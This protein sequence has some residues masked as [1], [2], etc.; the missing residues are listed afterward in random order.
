MLLR[1][2][3]LAKGWI[4][5]VIFGLLILTFALWGVHSYLG[6][7]GERYVAEVN[8]EII[9][10]REF[11]NIVQT[12]RENLRQMFGGQLPADLVSDEMIRE[13]ALES[14]IARKLIE[15]TLSTYGFAVSDAEVLAHIRSQPFF[16][17]DGRFSAQRYENILKQQRIA[18]GG[19]EASVREQLRMDQLRQGVA[20]TAFVTPAE[21]DD[22]V[23]LKRQER[24]LTY[25]LISLEALRAGFAPDEAEI[26]AYYEA[27]PQSF[28]SPERVRIEYVILDEQRLR[29]EVAATEEDLRAYYQSNLD[30]YITP[31]TRR[32]SHILVPVEE[33]D[34]EAARA[35][36]EALVERIRAGESFADVA[37]EASADSLSA[38]AGG[39]LGFLARGDMEPA[40]EDVLFVLEQGQVSAPVRTELG[41]QILT[42]TE[43]KP[44]QQRP[45]AEVRDAIEQE[46]RLREA[47][48]R[49]FVLSERLRTAS[50]EQQDSLTPAAAA[51]GAELQTSDWFTLDEGTGF[52]ADAMIRRAAFSQRVLDAGQ[53]SDLLELADGRLAVL[54]VAAHEPSAPR[55]FEAVRDEA[56]A[57]LVEAGARDRVRELGRAALARLREGATLEAA[58]RGIPAT[59][60]RPGFVARDAADG[61]PP[62]LLR[63][64]FTLNRPD[65]GGQSVDGLQLASGDYALLV[66]SAVRD[67]SGDE[68]H[69]AR[70]ALEQQRA[71]AALEFDA[72]YGALESRAEIR[73]YR[74]N[75]E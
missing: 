8:G 75:L 62:A 33:G 28:M 73:I 4:A 55:P 56:R 5:Y 61:V 64:A 7:G 70:Y 16:Q 39:D 53:N 34:V 67:G 52:A 45:F 44:A 3:D 27:N 6:G 15:Q 58:V 20:E 37:R 23:R 32:A 10:Q 72:F 59:L 50:F 14:A 18:K 30:A 22:L 47:E 49:F 43:I 41:W 71:R 31:E 57:M 29:E 38:P 40:F 51:I 54:R 13:R 65:A 9:T 36:A 46:Y 25:A 2:H 21:R 24:E 42:V 11:R 1:I 69:Q 68:A 26:R 74:E 66:V 63:R 12:E 48:D 60:E 35:R 19:Y 17:E